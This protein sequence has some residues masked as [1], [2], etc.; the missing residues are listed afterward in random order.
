MPVSIGGNTGCQHPLNVNVG[1]AGQIGMAVLDS[2]TVQAEEHAYGLTS[3]VFSLLPWRGSSWT[4][5]YY[6]LMI[7][8]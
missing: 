1:L 6:P 4:V 7:S 8:C 2:I 3:S 5:E